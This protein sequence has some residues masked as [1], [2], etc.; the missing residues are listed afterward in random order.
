MWLEESEIEG[1][2]R[3]SF[4]E[5]VEV[6]R[7]FIKCAVSRLPKCFNLDDFCMALVFY[8]L[9]YMGLKCEEFLLLT[10][11]MIL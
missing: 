5:K 8:S 11:G 4:K 2:T 3:S 9:A 1:R 6:V 7:T 10:L